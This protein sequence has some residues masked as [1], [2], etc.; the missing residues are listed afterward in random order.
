MLAR[1]LVALLLSMPATV[2]LLGSFLAIL[3]STSQFTLPALLMVFPVWVGMAC[4]SY[5]MPTARGAAAVLCGLTALGFGLI[6]A[7]KFLGISGV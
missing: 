6:A 4:A 5:L 3:P 2:A 7:L 1:S